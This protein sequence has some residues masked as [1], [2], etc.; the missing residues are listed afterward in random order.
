MKRRA[1]VRY[2]LATAAALSTPRIVFA[3]VDAKAPPADVLAVTGDGREV[4]LRGQDIAD[5]AAQLRGRVLLAGDPGYDQ[6]RRI[7]NPSFN[8][9]P[10]L[11]VQVSG[12]ADVQA[13]VRF[14][15]A[16]ALLVAVKCGG[17]SHSG[18]ST[19]DRGMQIDLTGL[20][21]VR[22]DPRARRAWVEGG[23]LLGQ[24]DHESVPLGLVAPLGTV[25]HTG[26]GGLTL[27]GGFGRL[28]R[29]FELAA[30]NVVS[31]DIVTADGE[32][33]FASATEN[34]DLFWALRGGGGNFG[35]VTN[36]EFALHPM[37]REIVN[38]G[39]VFPIARASDVLALYAEY[40]PRAPDAL[41]MDPMLLLPPGGAPG[42]AALTVT[43]CGPEAEAEA[44][45]APLRALGTPLRDTIEKRDY[46]AV[47]RA[48]DNDD[49]RT[50]SYI[51]GGFV[52]EIPPEFIATAV[53]GLQG[54]PGRTTIFFAQQCGGA[55]SRVPESATAFAHR[56]AQANFM[57]NV[58]WPVGADPAPHISWVR[59]YWDTLEPYSRGFYVN[60]LMI[61][62]PVAK[63]NANYRG[64][65]ARLEAVK[66]RYDPTNLFRLN[67]NV[68]PKAA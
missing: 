18:Q 8:K 49:P 51:K 45:F 25:S 38:G 35:V 27:G 43:W 66:G 34:P 41:Y 52:R 60:D 7:L 63:V 37:Q 32:L 29:R 23:S 42:M 56:D 39:L 10:A 55:I 5:L 47:Q 13:A 26:V 64:N 17:H 46:L 67:A 22:V 19:C 24:V 11:I 33:R 68:Q 1:F 62:T 28:A 16:S 44:A 12:V 40:A 65:L 61:D 4:V 59:K 21:G 48:N 57:A 58:M 9:F 30:D 31:M 20:R 14:A 50:G 2:S 15:R 53:S 3:A 54:D 6:A 36:F